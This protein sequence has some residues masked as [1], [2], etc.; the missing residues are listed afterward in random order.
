MSSAALVQD[1]AELSEFDRL[2]VNSLQ[3]GFPLTSSPYEALAA[4]LGCDAADILA[5]IENLLERGIVTRFGPLLNVERAGGAYSL[6]ALKVPESR[7]DAVA[8]IVNGYDEVAH[9][10]RRD[11]EWNMWFVLACESDD[12]LIRAYDA[13][14][15]RTGC[16]GMNL[17]KER[18]YFVGVR[19]DV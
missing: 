5:G 10:Y 2:L 17:P 8:A 14:V 15:E 18:E 12:E 7:F 3:G 13:I 6:C 16:A 1:S 11:H 4:R 19:F 9:N